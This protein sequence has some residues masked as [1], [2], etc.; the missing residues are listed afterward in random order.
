MIEYLK[1]HAFLIITIVAAA[2]ILLYG[3]YRIFAG[4]KGTWS[5]KLAPAPRDDISSS[6]AESKGE[7]RARI[8]LE[9]YFQ[10]PF[11]RARP[12]FLNNPVTGYN[13]EIDC[14]NEELKLGVEYQGEQHYNF[15]P[16][17]HASR[18]EFKNQKYRDELKRIY[19]A[20]AGVLLLEIPYTALSY[21]ESYLEKQLEEHFEPNDATPE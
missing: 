10:R 2:I 3:L 4:K 12:D 21:L 18:A 15:N 19:A 7:K 20:R 11:V 9:N 1:H 14:Y 13:L 16:Y 17:W 8:F 6:K 5:S